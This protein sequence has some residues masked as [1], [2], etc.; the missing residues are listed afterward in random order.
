MIKRKKED[1]E[2]DE[3]LVEELDRNSLPQKLAILIGSDQDILSRT[4]KL[5][6][7]K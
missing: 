3:K 4:K 6:S 7:D 5:Q 1:E 2:D